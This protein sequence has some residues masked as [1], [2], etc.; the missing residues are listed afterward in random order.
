MLVYNAIG[1][2]HCLQVIESVYK[3]DF[4]ACSCGCVWVDGGI[5][6][7][8]R[9]NNPNDYYELSLATGTYDYSVIR[10]FAF[11]LLYNEGQYRTIRLNHAS[12]FIL[13][14]ALDK[15]IDKG[16]PRWRLF[17]EEKLYRNEIL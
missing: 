5:D 6:Y 12:D 17:L 9:S 13:D 3:H 4:K 7:I 15:V 11:I 2:K 16:G 8:G 10:T 1:C 14:L